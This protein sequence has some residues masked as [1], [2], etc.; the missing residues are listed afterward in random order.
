MKKSFDGGQNASASMVAGALI[1]TLVGGSS[2]IGT[3]QLAYTF[4]F[5]AW[6]FTLGGGL[7][8][9]ILA[10]FFLKPLYESNIHTLPE[11]FQQKYGAKAAKIA[12]VLNS[13]GTF[14]SIIANLLSGVALITALTSIPQT[15]ALVITVTLTVCYVI[16]GG[17]LSL[18]YIG[19]AKTILLCLSVGICGMLAIKI[20]GF[21]SI[22][23]LPHSQYLSV[24]ARGPMKDLGAGLSLI[25]GVLTTQSYIGAVL[26]AKNMREAKKGAYMTAVLVPLIGLAGVIVG[27]SMTMI[28]EVQDTKLV[29]PYFILNHFPKGVAYGILFVLLFAVIGTSAGLSL[30][31]ASM[32]FRNFFKKSKH[33]T[34]GIRTIILGILLAA[35]VICETGMDN[36]ILNW[37]FMS[38]GLRGAVA[39]VPLF[40]A[41]FI[42]KYIKESFVIAAMVG[43][44]LFTVIGNQILPADIDPM[45]LGIIVAFIIFMTGINFGKR[46][47]KGN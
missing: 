23:A 39:F 22:L 36:L 8:V 30:G 27:L 18:S 11:L 15:W 38:M 47:K 21:H 7:G 12:T 5:S 14:L 40:F 3:A 2:T 17:A 46:E 44:P 24:I 4:G 41:F 1:G 45:F 33:E 16:F 31:M 43:G 20:V 28:M 19:I 13:V 10:L 32:I 29:L 37:S 25:I 26:S 6:W 9:L 34:A 35:F 42:R